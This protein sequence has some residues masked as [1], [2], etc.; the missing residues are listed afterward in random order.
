MRITNVSYYFYLQ[1]DDLQ[2]PLA[3]INLFTFPDATLLSQ[4]SQTVYLCNALEGLGAI[5]VI[6]ITSIKSVVSMFTDLKVTPEGELVDTRKFA[7]LRHPFIELAKYNTEGL[8]D[9]E[10]DDDTDPMIEY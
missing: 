6:P 10:D 8:F 5:K 7:L 2:Y 4:S 9:E 1:F 3:V